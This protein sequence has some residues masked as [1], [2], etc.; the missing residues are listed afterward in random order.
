M[1]KLGCTRVEFDGGWF[2]FNRGGMNGTGYSTTPYDLKG[3]VAD[4]HSKQMT[5][6]M[7]V[8]G[9][10]VDVYEK[11]GKWAQF[12]FAECGVDGIKISHMCANQSGYD[13]RGDYCACS[14][15]HDSLMPPTQRAMMERW[16]AAI[17]AGNKTQDVQVQNCVV[18]WVLPRCV[19][20]AVRPVVLRDGHSLARQSGRCPDLVCHVHQQPQSDD[21][22]RSHLPPGGVHGG[23]QIHSRSASASTAGRC[24]ARPEPPFFFPLWAITSSPLYLGMDIRTITKED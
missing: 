1:I 8:T 17:A 22:T 2:N 18:R 14:G 9:G 10:F 11:E 6:G 7:C 23:T 24:P 20:Y 13:A 21:R 15:P 16:T 3:I 5:L 19:L 12:L 4:L